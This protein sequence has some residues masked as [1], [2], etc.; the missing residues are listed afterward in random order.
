MGDVY[1]SARTLRKNLGFSLVAITTLALGVGANTAIFSVVKA[2]LL[3]QLPYGEPRRLVKIAETDPDT[4]RP[5]TVDFTSSLATTARQFE[6]YPGPRRSR[7]G[8]LPHPLRRTLLPATSGYWWRTR[9]EMCPGLGD[10]CPCD[11]W[12]NLRMI[13]SGIRPMLCH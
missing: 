4:P 10:R 1:F 3:N 7:R 2:V 9:F 12:P 5:V 11:R 8:C 13:S 6:M